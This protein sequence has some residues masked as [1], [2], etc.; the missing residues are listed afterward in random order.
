MKS[1]K[2]E[3]CDHTFNP[4]IGC[5]RVSPGCA[6]CYAANSTRARVLRAAGHETWGKGAPRSRTQT[7]REPIKWN[8][9]AAL[10]LENY[11]TGVASGAGMTELARPRVFC[12]SL[13]DWLDD[14]V[15]IEWLADL[16]ALV[17]LT[18]NL[19]WLLLTKRPENWFARVA[20]VRDVALE[21]DDMELHGFAHSWIAR[22]DRPAPQNVWVGTTVE[23]QEMADKRIPLLLSIPA[24]VRFLSCEPLLGPVDLVAPLV[25]ARR[26]GLMSEGLT[27]EQACR[28]ESTFSD[29]DGIHWVIAGGESGPKARPMHPDWARSLRDQCQAADVPFLFKQWGEHVTATIGNCYDGDSRQVELDGTDSSDWTIDRHTASTEIMVKIGKKKAGRLLDGREWNEFPTVEVN[30]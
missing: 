18:P 12:A 19:D 15:P 8:R 7:W 20:G 29:L 2:I 28:V 1:S 25:A 9:E 16:L 26:A 24:K 4:W 3:W 23:N 10:S 17:R 11:N 14:E 21:R 30:A 27:D 13:A 6:H 22:A 5:T